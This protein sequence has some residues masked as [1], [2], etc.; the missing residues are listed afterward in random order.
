V[1]GAV[2][3]ITRDLKALLKMSDIEF[4]NWRREALEILSK[5]R[6]KYLAAL[7]EASNAEFCARAQKAWSKTE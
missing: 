6:S 1:I 7:Y 4:L 2:P 3:D 5:H